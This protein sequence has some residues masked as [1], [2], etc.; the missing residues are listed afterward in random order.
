MPNFW[1]QKLI[2]KCCIVHFSSEKDEDLS[3]VIAR[4]H[5]SSP[6][7]IL[8]LRPFF[9]LEGGDRGEIDFSKVSFG[10]F[11]IHLP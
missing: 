9:F 4:Q 6:H 8:T 3:L 2:L 1:V 11:N 5:F 10:T 7:L